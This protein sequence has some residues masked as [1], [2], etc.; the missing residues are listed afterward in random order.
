MNQHCKSHLWLYF[1]NLYLL[2]TSHADLEESS[3]DGD[4]DIHSIVL[5]VTVFICAHEAV[6]SLH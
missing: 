3:F 2:V 1:D 5:P 4:Y 6:L